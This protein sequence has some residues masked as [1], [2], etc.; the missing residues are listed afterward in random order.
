MIAT[1]LNDSLH[2]LLD[3]N[4][5][6]ATAVS[7]DVLTSFVVE[8]RLP[9]GHFIAEPKAGQSGMAAISRNEEIRVVISNSLLYLVDWLKTEGNSKNPDYTEESC[10]YCINKVLISNE[11][12]PCCPECGMRIPSSEAD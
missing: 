11:T 2:F 12:I 9:R 10:P 4:K 6:Y 3:A 5:I 7:R 8:N 1:R